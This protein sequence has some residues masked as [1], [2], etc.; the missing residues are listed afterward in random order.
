MKPDKRLYL[1]LFILS[2]GL[3][4]VSCEEEETIGVACMTYEDCS[5]GQQCIDGYCQDI[6]DSGNTTG[7]TGNSADSVDT[8]NSA[9]TGNTGNT[10]NSVDDSDTGNTGNSVDDSDT[11]N[12]GNSVDDSDTAN[13]GDSVDDSDSGDTDECAIDKGGCDQIC[14]NNAG[15]R[16]CS[17]NSGYT[18]NADGVSC[19]DIDECTE[20]DNPCNDGDDSNATCANTDGGYTCSCSAGFKDDG[21]LCVDIDEC[22]E[23]GHNCDTN[24]DCTNSTGSFTCACKDYYDGDGT[25]CT[26]CNTDSQCESGCTACS[27]GTPKCKDNTGTTAC[28]ECLSNAECTAPKTCNASNQCVEPPTTCTYRIWAEPHSSAENDMHITVKDAG[29]TV[30]SVSGQNIDENFVVTHAHEIT[31]TFSV[32]D[33]IWN[34]YDYKIY[35]NHNIK[36]RDDTVGSESWSFTANCD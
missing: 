20:N 3:I 14:T 33:A 7:D 25:S 15:G 28:V 12:T 27:G 4:A 24:A 21:T 8:G 36:I 32:S 26:Y 22:T 13:S 19:D 18:L 11:A 6:A 16:T 31:V 29:S 2:M 35:N 10:G 9:D 5:F 23:G 1:I 17:C 30:L 34:Q